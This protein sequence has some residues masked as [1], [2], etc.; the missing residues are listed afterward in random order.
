VSSSLTTVLA[1]MTNAVQVHASVGAIEQLCMGEPKAHEESE[2]KPAVQEHLHMT[3]MH[4]HTKPA[5]NLDV[6]NLCM[7]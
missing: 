2:L 4:M 7:F 5:R 1:N 3:S 6:L